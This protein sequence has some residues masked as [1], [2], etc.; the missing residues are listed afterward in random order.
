MKRILTA[1]MVAFGLGLSLAPKANAA[2]ILVYDPHDRAN[3][4]INLL[5]T[6]HGDTITEITTN[7]GLLAAD[8]SLFDIV[9][10]AG[11]FN[12][13][14]AAAAQKV[15]DFVN[16]GGG[17][18]G[19]TE[20][21]CCEAHNDWVES[22][23]KTLTG[24]NAMQFGINGDGNGEL[25]QFLFPDTTILLDPNDIRGTQMTISAPGQLIVTDQSKIFAKQTGP[26]GFNIGVAYATSDLVNHAGRI[27][28]IS[29]IDWMDSFTTDEAKA[30]ANIRKF[31]LAGESLPPGCGQNPN[32]PECQ[33][34]NVPEPAAMALF[35]AGLLAVV[36][37]R[38][39]AAKQ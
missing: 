10:D 11:H 35:G 7:A 30:V 6:Q 25:G 24:D 15:V 38:R 13:E 23:F 18:Y 28:T 39:K 20:R 17:F 9:W 19:Q 27:V 8:F 3:A 2:A 37:R 4:L 16:A 1:C 26:G 33:N 12:N 29:D 32:L 14:G 34:P 21:P 22:I 5:Q 31:L 36:A